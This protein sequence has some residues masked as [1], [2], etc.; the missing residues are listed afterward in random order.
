MNNNL[1]RVYRRVEEIVGRSE[2]TAE[3]IVDATLCLERHRETYVYLNAMTFGKA[4]AVAES[5]DR[6]AAGPASP[7]LTVSL[8]RFFS[9]PCFEFLCNF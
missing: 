8:Y 9:A 5:H 6:D 7:S 4:P 3:A 2:E 1:L